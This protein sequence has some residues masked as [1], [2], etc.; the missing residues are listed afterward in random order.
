MLVPTNFPICALCA[1]YADVYRV[2]ANR[3]A[4]HTF[5]ASRRNAQIGY[6]CLRFIRQRLFL[7]VA[8]W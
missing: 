8:E 3:R 5:F 4:V 7:S 2:G 1:L 6:V